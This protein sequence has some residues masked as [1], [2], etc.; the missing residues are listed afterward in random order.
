MHP[1]RDLLSLGAGW[2][3]ASLG[4]VAGLPRLFFIFRRIFTVK[5]HRCG[6][7]LPHL[8]DFCVLVSTGAVVGWGGDTG[9]PCVSRTE[10][11][12]RPE[13]FKLICCCSAA[14]LP[15][16]HFPPLPKIRGDT[17]KPQR[18]ILGDSGPL[19]VVS[20]TGPRA[21][22][23]PRVFAVGWAGRGAL[24]TATGV[25]LPQGTFCSD[26]DVGDAGGG[27]GCP[28][29]RSAR[30]GVVEQRVLVLLTP[31]AGQLPEQL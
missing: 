11:R 23:P 14:S 26:A 3:T 17:V 13:P 31:R 30:C 18:D 20:G 22:M 16:G 2:T 8:A 29:G 6:K 28:A 4:S 25:S 12:R 7:F 5:G 24:G 19:A 15:L 1:S 27:G 10:K 9:G 21:E